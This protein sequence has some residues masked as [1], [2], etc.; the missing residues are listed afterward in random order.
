[1]KKT[2]TPHQITGF[3]FV[4]LAVQAAIGVASDAF[5]LIELNMPFCFQ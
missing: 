3:S 2:E 1:L 5:I 4:A